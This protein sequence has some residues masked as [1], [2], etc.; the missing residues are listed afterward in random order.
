MHEGNTELNKEKKLMIVYSIIL[1]LIFLLP[2]YYDVLAAFPHFCLFQQLFS[3]NCPGCGML[4][5][6]VE[7]SSFNLPG[8]MHFNPVSLFFVLYVFL[9]IIIRAKLL[10]NKIDLNKRHALSV[11]INRVFTVLLCSNWIITGFN[12]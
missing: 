1:G 8:A 9:E 6:I 4:R 10:Q 11:Q 3:I 7:L 5:G 12:P 2:F